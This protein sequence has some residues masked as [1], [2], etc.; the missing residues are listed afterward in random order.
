[1][2]FYLPCLK[3]CPVNFFETK[4]QRKEDGIYL[5]IDLIDSVHLNNGVNRVYAT[6]FNELSVA[7]I[8]LT[9]K[10]NMH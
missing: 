1:M 6:E 4:I 9:V 10:E 8:L 5:K 2:K 7:H 3:N